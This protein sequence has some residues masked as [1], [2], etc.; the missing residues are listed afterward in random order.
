MKRTWITMAC[1]LAGLS[2]AAIAQAQEPAPPAFEK[3]ADDSGNTEEPDPFDADANAPKLVQV[4]VE[5]VEMPHDALTKLLFLAKPKSADATDLRKQVQDMVSKKEAWV[6]ETQ[7]VVSRSG[8]KA[9]SES[10]HEFIYPTEFNPAS[11][12]LKMKDTLD[13]AMLSGFPFNPATPTAFETRNL[14]STLEV[15]PTLGEDDRTIDLRFVPEII[16][17]TGNTAWHEGKDT[18]GNPFKVQMPDFYTIKLNTAITCINGQ[19]TMTGVVSPKD[20]NGETD[21]TRK[22][23]VFV[24][25]DVLSVK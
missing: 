22:V 12:E 9:T 4:Q 7:I 25:C 21:M 19:Y 20:N 6:I 16:C 2:F 5:F 10:I 14:G 23:M 8:H 24:K 11:V 18:N 13:K 1:A 15:E 17:H 3:S